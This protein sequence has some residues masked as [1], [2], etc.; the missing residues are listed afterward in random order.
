[1]SNNSRPLTGLLTWERVDELIEKIKMIGPWYIHSPEKGMK[2]LFLSK[3]S[4]ASLFLSDRSEEIKSRKHGAGWIYVHTPEA[5]S[6]IKIYDPMK[7]GSSCSMTTPKAWWEMTLMD[8]RESLPP[9]PQTPEKR[10]LTERKY[11]SHF[12]KFFS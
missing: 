5:P 1:M 12:G 6:W 10:G 2:S 3:G 9:E 4:E 11:F 8:P 7:C